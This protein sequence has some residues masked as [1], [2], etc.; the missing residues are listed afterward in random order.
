MVRTPGGPSPLRAR[1]S[2]A[3]RGVKWVTTPPCPYAR[4]D[5]SPSPPLSPQVDPRRDIPPSVRPIKTVGMRSAPLAAMRRGWSS[6]RR[7]PATQR[8]SPQGR[9]STQRGD[10]SPTTRRG[11]IGSAPVAR[12][13]RIR[14]IPAAMCGL[15]MRFAARA[16]AGRTPQEPVPTRSPGTAQYRRT[17][18]TRRHSRGGE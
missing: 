18:D 8:N 15:P 17:G 4:G 5:T 11:S 16:S 7:L 9:L 14:P 13:P 12:R 1:T 3:A 2:P 6:S 10:G